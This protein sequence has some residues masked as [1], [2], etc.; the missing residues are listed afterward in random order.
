MIEIYNQLSTSNALIP[1]AIGFVLDDE[2]R[3]EEQK[4]D[5]KNRSDGKAFFLPRRMY[6]NYLLNPRGIADILNRF[7]TSRAEPVTD[8]QVRELLDQKCDDAGYFCRHNHPKE[9]DDQIQHIDATKVLT[10]IFNEIS[11]TRVAFDKPQYSVLLTDWI[12]ENSPDDLRE[13]A[14]FLARDVLEKNKLGQ[15]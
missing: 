2:G 8:A 1:P 9:P 12:I 15:Q 11:E 6:E 10:D 3:A 13:L 5:I 7:D 4:L 14:D